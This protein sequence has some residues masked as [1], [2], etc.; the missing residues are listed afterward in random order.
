MRY[1]WNAA[2]NLLY[3]PSCC[4]CGGATTRPGF[5]PPCHATIALPQSPLCTICG[6]PFQTRAG[7]DHPCGRCLTRAPR[8]GRARACALYDARDAVTRDAVTRDVVTDGPATDPLRSVLQR[9]KY[10]RDVS[11]AP[12]LG[13]LLKQRAPLSAAA[14]DII[15]PVPLHISRLRWRGFNQAHLL[16]QQF[17]D[18]TAIDPYSLTRVRPTQP[19]VEL[20]ESE[21]RRNVAGAFRV[22]RPERIDGRRVLLVDDVYT[23]GATVDECSHMLVRAG[24]HCVDVLVLARAVMH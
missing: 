21:R 2:L 14:Y 22:T 9:Y 5:C 10:N 15:I 23:T 3:P 1:W 19:Q 13:A 18:G 20:H 11:L 17:A 12:V 8:F 16:A 24:A 4:G 6:A 7:A